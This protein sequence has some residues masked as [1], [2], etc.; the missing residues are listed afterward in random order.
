[1][2]GKEDFRPGGYEV[3]KLDDVRDRV[4]NI[5]GQ[6]K[7]LATKTDVAD[8]KV[9]ILIAWCGAAATLLAAAGIVLANVLIK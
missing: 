4:A 1:M 3:Q 6:M 7:S 2:N 5:E 9:Q 8:A